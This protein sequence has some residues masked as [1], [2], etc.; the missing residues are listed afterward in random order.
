MMILPLHPPSGR[1]GQGTS[2]VTRNGQDGKAATLDAHDGAIL[3]EDR[4]VSPVG[5]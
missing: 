4:A 2:V 5:P 1:Y 3:R